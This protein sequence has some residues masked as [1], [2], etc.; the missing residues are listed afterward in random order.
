VCAYYADD[1]KLYT[2][3]CLR[4]SADDLEKAI[5]RLT[6]WAETWQLK[7]APGKC[8]VCRLESTWWQ[9]PHLDNSSVTN[10]SITNKGPR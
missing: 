9:T 7:L 10:S 8:T 3:Y 2:S 6:I 1:I 5:D 4:Q